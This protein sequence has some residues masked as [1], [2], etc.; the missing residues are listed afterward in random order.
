M[1]VTLVP[2]CLMWGL[3]AV[4][5]ELLGNPVFLPDWYEASYG[6]LFVAFSAAIMFT[7]FAYFLRFERSGWSVLDPLQADAYGIFLVHYPIVLWLQYWLFD[8]DLPAIVK[9][10]VTFALTVALSWAATAALRRIP[11]ATHVL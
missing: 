5:R 4:K 7:I 8:F 10:V 1:I 3:I 9:A 6:L 2:Y 11:E